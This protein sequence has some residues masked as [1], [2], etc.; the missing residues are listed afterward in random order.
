MCEVELAE[1]ISRL[2]PDLVNGHAKKLKQ[3]SPEKEDGVVV[4]TQPQPY[5][6]TPNGGNCLDVVHACSIDGG[7]RDLLV[8]EGWGNGVVAGECGEGAEK[9]GRQEGGKEEE[10]EERKRA[11]EEE[12]EMEM[13]R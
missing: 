8:S 2:P 13:R 5:T 3:A 6:P 10:E 12:V 7:G 9:M 4:A 1:L 11:E